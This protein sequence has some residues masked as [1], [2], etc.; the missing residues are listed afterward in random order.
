VSDP[1]CA[2]CGGFDIEW[3][4]RCEKHKC[5]TCRGCT[6]PWC[7]EEEMD[8]DYDVDESPVWP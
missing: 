6:C 2:D 8:G 1:I 5:Y 7:E 3:M 4:P